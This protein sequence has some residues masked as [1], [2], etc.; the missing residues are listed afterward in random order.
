[1]V[2]P[3]KVWFTLTQDED[4][5]PPA[6]SEGL[7]TIPRGDGSFEIDNIPLFLLGL[8]VGDVV[9][10][11]PDQHGKLWFAELVERGSHSTIHIMCTDEDDVPTARAELDKLGCS[12]E[13]SP[14]ERLFAVDVP[15]SVSRDALWPW[16]EAGERAGRWVY[17]EASIS[18]HHQ[19]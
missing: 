3:E 2:A 1:M 6:E 16:L 13:D 19:E 5:W 4:G 14:L 11:E 8:A 18:P 15:G 7:W 10:A 17:Q 9:R 12:S